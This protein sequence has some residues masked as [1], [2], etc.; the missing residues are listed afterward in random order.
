VGRVRRELDW[1]A[2]V[3]VRDLGGLIARDGTTTRFR[4]VI[5]SDTVAGLTERGWDALQEYGV[6]TIVDLRSADEVAADRRLDEGSDWLVD[7]E[8]LDTAPL[9]RPVRTV[10]V[11]VL[12]AWTPELEALFDEVARREHEPVAST[13]AVYLAVLDLFAQNIATAITAIADAPPGGVVVHCQ[14]GKD[15]TGTVC[16]LV[17]AL[18]DVE[19]DAIADDYALSGPNIAPLHDVWVSEA[20]DEAERDRRKRIGLSPRQA[21]LDVL[22]ELEVRWSGTEGYLRAA[23]VTAKTLEAVQARLS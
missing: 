5:R 6:T 7:D 19:P 21:M 9:T 22:S 4:A 12:G 14:A 3:N 20:S 2:C 8:L 13:R 17:L 1:Q 23:G 15:R 10:S 18:V 16:A 11:P